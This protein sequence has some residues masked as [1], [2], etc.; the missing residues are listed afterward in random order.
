MNRSLLVYS[1]ENC[2]VHIVYYFSSHT[3]TYMLH[4]KRI[5]DKIGIKVIL[6][7]T[8]YIE[9]VNFFLEQFQICI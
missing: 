2:N 7:I 9:E 8:I 6:H 4:M 3:Y 5:F 1:W